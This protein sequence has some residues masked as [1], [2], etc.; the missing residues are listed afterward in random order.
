MFEQNIP[1]EDA[2]NLPG[3]FHSAQRKQNQN[4]SCHPHQDIG[5]PHSPERTEQA[6]IGKLLAGD[7][8][9]PVQQEKAETDPPGQRHTAAAGHHSQRRAD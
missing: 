4:Q 7:K 2:L 6:A 9:D 3:N 1:T 5:Q 8:S